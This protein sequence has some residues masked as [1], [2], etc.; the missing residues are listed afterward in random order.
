MDVILQEFD[1]EFTKSKSNNSLVLAEL[2]C[3]LPSNSNATTSE[4]SIPDKS[5]FLIR[6]YDPWYGDFII[7]L[8][9]QIF[10]PDT[11][12]SNQ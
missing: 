5:L 1:L 12:C 11:S 3:D 10:L 2:L 8:W 7:Y 6:S 9:T 4:P